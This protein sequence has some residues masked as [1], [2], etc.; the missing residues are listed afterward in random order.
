MSERS[1]F[2]EALAN[3]SG[4]TGL[5][6]HL[7]ALSKDYTGLSS[8]PPGGSIFSKVGNVLGNNDLMGNITG[9]GSTLASL[10]ALPSQIDWAKANTK[11][12]KQ[13]MA[14]TKTEN[15]RRDKNISGFN[16]LDTSKYA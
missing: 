5:A 2:T 11:A 14:T 6:S 4:S 16:S 7:G 9:L 1:F 15:A 12:L 8:A 3:N 13:N 10:A